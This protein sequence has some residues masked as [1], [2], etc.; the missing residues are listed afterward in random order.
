MSSRSDMPAAGRWFLPALLIF[1]LVIRVLYLLN[2]SDLPQWEQL[3]VDNYYHHHW[4]ETLAG[5]N[6][7]G[8][9]TY[10]RAPFYIYVLGFVYTFFGASLWAA[11][12]FGLVVG[13]ASIYC[14]YR[15]GRKAFSHQLGLVAATVQAINP[16]FLYFEAELL[17]DVLFTLLLQISLLTVWH[18][19]DNRK[20]GTL[21]L[22]GLV[23]GV[24]AI[25]RPTALVWAG[26]VLAWLLLLS[27][28]A[29]DRL[30]RLVVFAVG[31]ALVIG[32]IFVRNLYVADDPVL[33]ASQGGI[34]F[35][36]GNNEIA[37]GVS[38]RMP[39]P[40][41][42]NWRLK[43]V[44]R[45]AEEASARRLKPGE[46][47]DYW[48]SQAFQWI[49]R[50]PG[51]FVKLY[52]KKMY[53]SIGDREVSN[54]RDL[55][56]F[57]AAMPLLRLNPVSFSIILAFAVAGALIG[58]RHGG[59]RVRLL[60]GLI[61]TYLM[62]MALFFFSSRFR[63]PVLPFMTVL[64]AVGAMT[65]LDL[66]ATDIKRGASMMLAVVTVWAFSY[67]PMVKLPPGSP[68]QD[69]VSKG[70]H[71]Y[72][73]GDF[74]NALGYFQAARM[75]DPPPAETNLNIGACYLRLGIADSALFY[76]EQERRLHSNRPKTYSNL[77]SLH[78]INGRYREAA[79]QA[80]KALA[81]ADWNVT[82][83]MIY[84]RA[85]AGIDSI[86]SDSFVARVEQAAER[87]ENDLYLLNDAALLLLRRGDTAQAES[88]LQRA[89]H[90]RPPP[91]ET[92]DGAFDRNF[93]NH[94]LRRRHETARTHYHL[95]L[96]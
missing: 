50:N 61:L 10:F 60:I 27:G 7:L 43:Q 57:S 65:V 9:T 91:I 33:I 84:L 52:L 5:G 35:F 25:T 70:I 15:I 12:L 85:L 74:Q 63:V 20:L 17:L 67:Y 73:T 64:A 31:L 2:Y 75:Y 54:N 90:S 83:N 21:L 78:L 13:L 37:D 82:A 51:S 1:A 39:E 38:A 66:F 40:M 76:L 87:T 8:D 69:F 16:V 71:Y 88:L 89:L 79:A 77:A 36:I 34:N 14:T 23:T 68:A 24:A 93:P 62:T 86:T 95:G 55:G 80:E 11:R 19:L 96:L 58:W 26:L 92:D 6:I 30:K 81:L 46:V 45:A 94:F 42:H 28:D 49:V 41:G 72:A 22:A 4:A 56:L 44:V 3:T 18:W 32:P 47:S 59:S 29:A 53:L 48:T